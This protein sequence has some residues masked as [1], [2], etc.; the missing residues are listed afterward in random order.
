M[1]CPCKDC[2]DRTVTC[3]GVCGQYA[4]WKREKEA[5]KAS[6]GYMKTD[7]HSVAFWRKWARRSVRK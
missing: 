4:E 3:H 7:R 2:N 5:G 1:M 6:S